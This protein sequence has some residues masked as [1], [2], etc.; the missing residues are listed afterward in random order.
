MKASTQELLL[1]AIARRLRDDNPGN[2]LEVHELE[3]KLRDEV[4]A[5]P[6]DVGAILGLQPENQ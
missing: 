3:I 1:M 2:R 5:R 4:D 6:E